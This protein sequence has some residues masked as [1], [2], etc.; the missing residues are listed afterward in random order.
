M[1]E[2]CSALISTGAVLLITGL[3]GSILLRIPQ[4]GKL[5]AP[6]GLILIAFGLL[7]QLTGNC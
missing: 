6:I 1:T 2:F 5:G 7:A 4:I 3:G